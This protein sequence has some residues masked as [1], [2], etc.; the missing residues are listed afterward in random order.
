[1]KMFFETKLPQARVV[2]N[3][4]IVPSKS[5]VLHF[6]CQIDQVFCNHK[7]N[8]KNEQFYLEKKKKI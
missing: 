6:S 4:K 2:I 5:Q 1:M 3:Y 7:N 8:L